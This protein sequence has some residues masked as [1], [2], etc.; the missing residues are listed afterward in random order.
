MTLPQSEEP[1]GAVA[2]AVAAQGRAGLLRR[3]LRDPVAVTCLVLLALISLASLFAPLLTSQDPA[4][5]SLTDSLAPMSG[6]HPLGGDGVGRDVLARLLYGGRTSL[7][8]ALLAVAVAVVIGVP[9]GLVAGYYRKWFDAVSSWVSNLLMA[10]PAIIVLLVVMSAVGQNTYL[11]MA[12]FGV[13]MSPGVFR[14]IR[15]SVISVREEL[16]VDA[17]RVS[18]LTDAR[19]IRRHILPVVQAPTIIQAAQMLGLG[20]VIQSGLEF[21]GLGSATQASWGSMLNDAFGNIYTKPELMVWPGVALAVTVAA[22]GLLGN[23]LRDALDG[24]ATGGRR[25]SRG[26]T[27]RRPVADKKASPVIVGAGETDDALLVLEGLT[28]SYPTA[29]GEKTVVDGV[30]LTVRRGE[31]LGLVGESGSGKS[32]TA[33]AVL[34]LLPREAQVA[35]ARLE[36]DGTELGRLGR[37]AMNRYRGHRIAYVPQE[38]MSNLDPSFR[39]GAQLVEPVR[40]HLGLSATEAKAKTLGLLERVG[41][42]DPERVFRSY[43]HQISG[44]MAQRV[45]I[46]GAVSCE[47]DLLIA[48]EPT[49][50]LDVTVQAE[51]LDLMR[52]L[53]RERNMGVILVTHDFGVVADICDRVAVMQT[54]VV[55]ESAPVAELFADPQ[56]PYTRMLL[57]STLE[58]AEPRSALSPSRTVSTSAAGVT[59]TARQEGPA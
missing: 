52:S 27:A 56:H 29:Q 34:G 44:G 4:H 9:A 47:P 17:A 15:A 11:A 3:L 28:V 12:V 42:S 48:D 22:F 49:T 41:I 7:L 53:Q 38:P 2:T 46:A 5:T 19:I 39:I 18:G 50:A 43:P 36:F 20:I 45:L 31:V 25:P 13:L 10:V 40:R 24:S 21:L 59:N 1:A 14:L 37:A 54:G 26:A 6:K 8:G 57:S 23:A 35:T 51:V 55:V 33:F 30:S 58:D 16:Y 32:Q